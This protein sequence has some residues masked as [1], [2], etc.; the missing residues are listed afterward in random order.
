MLVAEALHGTRDD[1]IRLRRPAPC[2][3]LQ[4]D[5]DPGELRRSGAPGAR[6]GVGNGGEL[7]RTPQA[8][9]KV[10]V[11]PVGGPK[12]AQNKVKTL[13]KRRIQPLNQRLK[14]ARRSFSTRWGILGSS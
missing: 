9:E 1:A 2:R 7:R 11:G 4:R 12:D 8:V 13:Q 14:R 10:V 6:R 3:W 5:Q